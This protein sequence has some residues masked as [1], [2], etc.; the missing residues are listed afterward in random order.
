MTSVAHRM[1]V[2][3]KPFSE[4]FIQHT[5]CAL[6]CHFVSLSGIYL[7]GIGREDRNQNTYEAEQHLISTLQ[8]LWM[9]ASVNLLSYIFDLPVLKLGVGKIS[10]GPKMERYP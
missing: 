7:T 9:L 1:N 2:K 3:I 8:A 10:Y 6:V 5:K 4:L